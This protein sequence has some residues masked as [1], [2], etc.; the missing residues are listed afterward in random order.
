[1]LVLITSSLSVVP[2]PKVS[3]SSPGRR[4]MRGRFS[5]RGGRAV[6]DSDSDSSRT[7]ALGPNCRP[8]A[9]VEVDSARPWTRLGLVLCVSSGSKMSDSLSEAQLSLKLLSDDFLLTALPGLLR[10]PPPLRGL[11]FLWFFFCC[12][13]PDTLDMLSSGQGSTKPNDCFLVARDLLATLLADFFPVPSS[14]FS[15]LLPL[16][17]RPTWPSEVLVWP[18]VGRAK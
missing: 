16:F 4:A 9:A 8:A 15:Q 18:V 7:I 1:M 13:Q 3:G 17:F 2:L 12:S 5:L 14:N 11:L 6:E 10:P